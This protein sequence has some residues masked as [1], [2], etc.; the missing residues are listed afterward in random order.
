MLIRR[1]VL[2][3]LTVVCFCSGASLAAGGESPSDAVGVPDPGSLFS[4]GIVRESDVSAAFDYLRST[5]VAAAEGRDAPPVPEDLRRRAHAV[6]QEMRLRAMVGGILLLN[7]LERE[8]KALLA[9][10]DAA[11]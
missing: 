4:R 8:T 2:A 3:C 6:E 11:R 10:P 1:G 9:E 5:I 7:M